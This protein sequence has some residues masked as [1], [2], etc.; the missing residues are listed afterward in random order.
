MTESIKTILKPLASLR[1]TVSLLAMSMVLIFAATWAQID[2]GIW[3][4][5]EDYF[6]A[7]FVW[8]EFEN[9]LPADWQVSGGVPWPGGVLIGALLVINL[10][11]AH[12]LRFQIAWKRS[13][14]IMIHS[15]VLLFLVGEAVTGWLGDESQMP[16]YEGQTAHWSHDIREVELAIVDH[17]D[18]DHDRVVVVT[19]KALRNALKNGEPV[20]DVKLPFQVRVD[21]YMINS[22]LFERGADSEMPPSG[23]RGLGL[24]RGARSVPPAS[25]V[26]SD[27]VDFPAAWVTL[28]DNAESLGTYLVSPSLHRRNLPYHLLSQQVVAGGATYAMTLRFRRQ[29]HPF[30]IELTDFTHEQYTGTTIPRNFASDICLVDPQHEVDRTV[31]IYMNHPLRYQGQTFYQSGYI[32]PA[33]GT[34]LQVVANPGWQIPYV[35]FTLMAVGL[36]VHFGIVLVRFLSRNVAPLTT[37]EPGTEHRPGPWAR[38]LPRAAVVLCFVYLILAARPP[39]STEPYAL[40]SFARLPVSYQGRVKPFDTVARNT[41]T[42]L[43]GRQTLKH[44]DR[45]PSATEWLIDVLC[46]RRVALEYEVFRIDH[47]EVLALLGWKQTD[48]K[49]FSYNSMD[50]HLEDLFR[51]ARRADRMSARDRSS[52]E[53]KVLELA[54]HVSLFESLATHRNLHVV[55]PIDET[56]DWMTLPMAA[57][58]AQESGHL[59]GPVEAYHQMFKAYDDRDAPTF[60][61]ALARYTTELNIEQPDASTKAGFETFFNLYG[62]FG[63]AR[64]L[65]VLAAVLVFFSWL[66]WNGPLSATAY[67]IIVIS[68]ALHSLALVARIYLSG[69]PPVTNLYASAVFIGWGC[70]ITCLILERVYRNGIG[71]LLASVSG[72]LTLLVARALAGDGDTMA[73]LVAVLDTNFWL[74]THVVVVTLGYSATFLAGLIGIVYILR[75]VLTRTLSQEMSRRVAQML[76]GT[77]CFALLFSLVGTVLG[78]IWADQSWGR[79]WGWDPKENGALLIVMWNALVMHARWGGLAKA[80]GIAVLA[81]FGNIVTSWSWFGTNM[82]G[83]GLH[84]YGFIASAVFWLLLFIFSQIALM[85]L[86]LLPLHLWRSFARPADAS[87]SRR[88]GTATVSTSTSTLTSTSR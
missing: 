69:R 84:S 76:Y 25:G 32:P 13:G 18:P 2:Q 12:A 70:V 83:V 56:H 51:E 19:E 74:A 9:F 15:A 33:R 14:I 3:S 62:P 52:F 77:I 50:P 48:R 21:Q 86:G 27:N 28:E 43:S 30:T 63:H 7:V 72:F 59:P 41:L 78:G 82:L 31:K 1:I 26:D 29:Y 42:I 61:L 34:V 66:G 55:P 79:F 16:I 35:A 44:Q 17:S 54:N 65:Y 75:G 37:T 40:N 58:H 5:V 68:A 80:R 8:I 87:V 47:P 88:A 6:R 20:Q 49:R 36:L 45:K 81:I 73:V 60:N 39:R 46:K 57:N 67:R 23:T 24:T 10:L 71:T 4:V 11:A 22:R 85:A 38:I 64:V 53:V